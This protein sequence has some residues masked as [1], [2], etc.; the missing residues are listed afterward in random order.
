[1]VGG[2][3]S[4][5][6]DDVD[7]FL[8]TLSRAPADDVFVAP[9]QHPTSYSRMVTDLPADVVSILAVCSF[10]A[11]LD[12]MPEPQGDDDSSTFS[13]E[14]TNTIAYIA[15]YIL[16]KL[17]KKICPQC[18]SDCA[19]E[20]NEDSHLLDGEHLDFL[21]QKQFESVTDGLVFPTSAFVKVLCDM[22]AEYRLIIDAAMYADNV[23][24]TLVASLSK[25]QSLATIHCHTCHVDVLTAHLMVNV[26]LHHSIKVAN[27]DL[28]SMSKRQN[29][30]VL[31]FS[32]K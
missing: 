22:E 15:G 27:T 29:R 2:R 1:M 11:L 18:F 7:H 28:F 9:I 24:A 19:I 5:C 8:L 16:R 21:K 12:Q 10:P 13:T 20:K 25:V 14:E 31:K 26:R 17:K 4:N 32:H 3:N 6:E 30:K 23:K